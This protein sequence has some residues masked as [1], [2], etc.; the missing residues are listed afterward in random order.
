MPELTL[1]HGN[2][3]Y[4]SWSMRGWLAVKMSGIPFE[5]RLFDLSAPGI[6]EEIRRHSP[7]GKVPALQ[8]GETVIWDS[9]A[10]F[11]YVAEL[12]PERNLWPAYRASRAVARAVAAEMHSGFPDLRREMPMNVRR[13]SP[14][15]GR[16]PGSLEDI[17]RIQAL[18]AECRQSQGSEGPFLFGDWSLTDCMYAPVVSRFLTYE[19]D[20]DPVSR[21]Y[22][23]AVREHP[24]V[25][26]WC[27]DAEAE[28]MVESQ[29][30][31]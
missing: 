4:S 5:S 10:I 2:K 26:E 23:D 7:S 31:L 19:V 25:A 12:C 22:V 15:R 14:G 1:Y 29:F 3:N 11:E 28:P 30:D 18:W 17:A 13:S 21:A 6:R 9:L 24:D 27:R 16:T 8:D 20:L